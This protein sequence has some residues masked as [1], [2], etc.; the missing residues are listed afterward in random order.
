MSEGTRKRRWLSIVFV[1]VL[2]WGCTENEPQV[3]Y[4]VGNQSVDTSTQCKLQSTG[5]VTFKPFGYLDVSLTNTYLLFP[6]MTTKLTDTTIVTGNGPSELVLD[7]STIQILGARIS[8]DLPID[9]LTGTGL[10]F[11]DNPLAPGTGLT[12]SDPL[13]S[14]GLQDNFVFTTGT[15]DPETDA[16]LALEAVP[17]YIGEILRAAPALQARYSSAQII[18][19]VTVEGK[20]M[21]GTKVVS[22]EFIYPLNVCNGCLVY[23]PVSD[24][25]NLEGDP[26]IIV[27]CFPGQDD[28]LDCRLCYALAVTADDAHACF[29]PE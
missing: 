16:L 29:P 19:H 28:G 12:S 14:A 20:L 4:I 24:C 6:A 22:N 7:T 26:E 5:I 9:P 18:V 25:S 10:G 1:T 15:V 8:Y 17:P 27:P 3:L 2:L 11:L 13:E 23:F 21:D